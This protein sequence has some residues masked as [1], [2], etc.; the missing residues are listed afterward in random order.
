MFM[1]NN[2]RIRIDLEMRP[3]GK[4]ECPTVVVVDEAS[5]SPLFDGGG[6]FMNDLRPIFGHSL[7][8]LGNF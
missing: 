5:K 6:Q 2:G 7:G 4:N 8:E 1:E 3:S